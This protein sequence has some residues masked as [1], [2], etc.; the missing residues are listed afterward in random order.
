[1]TKTLRKNEQEEVSSLD[2]AGKFFS[3]QE[4]ACAAALLVRGFEMS[5]L[6]KGD[7][8]KV[9]FVFKGEKDIADTIKDFWDGRLPVDAQGYFNAIKRLK[10]QIY[11][12]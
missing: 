7:P 5:K 1:M 12:E 6:D 10:N 3:S 4:L 11:S 2:E 9:K 8:R